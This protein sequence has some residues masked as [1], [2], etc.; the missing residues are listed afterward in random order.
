MTKTTMQ[1]DDFSKASTALLD[2]V[3]VIINL[4]LDDMIA[5]VDQAEN[6]NT[7][8]DGTERNPKHAHDLR[9]LARTTAACVFL[10]TTVNLKG[11]P[12]A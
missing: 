9:V 5:Y 8:D 3:K 4:P 2:A 1:P 6:R 12:L 7:T 11:T 10:R